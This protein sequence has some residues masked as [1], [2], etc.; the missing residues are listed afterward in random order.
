[1]IRDV[2]HFTDPRLHK[3][4]SLEEIAELFEF[5]DEN[6]QGMISKKDLLD[7]F[8]LSERLREAKYDYKNFQN[9][10]KNSPNYKQIENNMAGIEGQVNDL[11]KNFDLTG[12]GLISPEEFFNII[13]YVYG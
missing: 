11:V 1:M 6:R 12:D 13:M 4:P 7:K 9:L 10:K 2:E 8:E 3:C 5:L